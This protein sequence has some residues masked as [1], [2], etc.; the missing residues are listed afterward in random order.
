MP[1]LRT[2]LDVAKVYTFR[3]IFIKVFK[4]IGPVPIAV[5]IECPSTRLVKFFVTRT[6]AGELLSYFPGMEPLRLRAL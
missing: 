5:A 4:A 6:T 1:A 2:C 3:W